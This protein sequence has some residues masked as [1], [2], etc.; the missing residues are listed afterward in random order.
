MF[1]SHF[2]II[3]LFTGSWRWGQHPSHHTVQQPHAKQRC[4]SV[5]L[6]DL[7]PVFWSWRYVSLMP[8]NRCNRAFVVEI[9]TAFSVLLV[10]ANPNMQRLYVSHCKCCYLLG[11]SIHLVEYSMTK[12]WGCGCR[13]HDTADMQVCNV[14]VTHCEYDM[15]TRTMC[16][17]LPSEVHLCCLLIWVFH[18]AAPRVQLFK[19]TLK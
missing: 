19:V 6:I 18:S 7:T 8:N 10:A 15:L 5:T 17:V 9:C 1:G 3:W 16:S 11:M 13:Q 14:A 12:Q 4:V 2:F